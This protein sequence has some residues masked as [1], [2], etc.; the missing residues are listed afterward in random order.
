M[1]EILGLREQSSSL[2]ELL[3]L[4]IQRHGTRVLLKREER[5][6]VPQ[7]HK[8]NL[9]AEEGSKGELILALEERGA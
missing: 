6:R 4:L 2:T 1:E 5:R 7:G 8:F 9:S 3:I